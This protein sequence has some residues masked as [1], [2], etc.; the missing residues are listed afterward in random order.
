MP[1]HWPARRVSKLPRPAHNWDTSVLDNFPPEDR[2][3]VG[4]SGGRD[5]VVLLAWLLHWGFSRLIVCHLDHGLRGRSAEADARFVGE[6]SEAHGLEFEGA[7]ADVRAFAKEHRQSIETAA[8]A[9]RYAFFIEVARRRRCRTIF[10]AHHADDLVETYLFNLFRGSGGGRSMQTIATRAIGKTELTIV[11]P[12]LSVWREEIDAHVASARLRYRED[13]SNA[14]LDRTRNRMR[15][16]MIPAL[17]AEFGR[18]IRQAV[19][20]AAAIASEE[21]ALL[22][23]LVP[24][25]TAKLKVRPL[26]EQPV[27]LQRRAILDWLRLHAIAE[28]GFDVVEEVRALLNADG[29]PAKVNLP[30]DRHARRRAGELFIE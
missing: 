24:P 10:L 5:S 6:L 18:G 28:I 30:G 22:A 25:V 7:E 16:Q 23:S 27:A 19:W 9:V 4:V 3:L 1:S 8:R 12:L 21:D 14:K 2:Y 17:E 11:R 29:K 15:H 26:R 13:A 20:R